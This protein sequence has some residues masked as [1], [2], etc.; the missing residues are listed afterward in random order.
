MERA[1]SKCDSGSFQA[2]LRINPRST[3]RRGKMVDD[4]PCARCDLYV[5]GKA[6]IVDIPSR[7]NSKHVVLELSLAWI[8]L[9]RGISDPSRAVGDKV[10]PPCPY[11]PPP[12]ARRASGYICFTK[13]G[14]LAH[15][16]RANG[17]C[18]QAR[19]RTR[20]L[21]AR[22]LAMAEHTDRS[23]AAST[24]GL[25]RLDHVNPELQKIANAR[26]TLFLRCVPDDFLDVAA[27]TADDANAGEARL[28]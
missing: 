4:A 20:V 17:R 22:Y 18:F 28:E 23:C 3:E 1:G 14:H 24:S 16:V 9:S 21:P 25:H 2:F 19:D 6:S 10:V 11:G 5:D 26:C 7:D 15:R 27:S 8:A 13:T 12:M